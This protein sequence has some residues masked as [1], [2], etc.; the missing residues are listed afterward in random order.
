M[1]P[2]AI[3]AITGGDHVAPVN[4]SQ[5]ESISRIAQFM[6]HAF[7]FLTRDKDPT[8]SKAI[9]GGEELA[10]VESA[11][12]SSRCGRIVTRSVALPGTRTGGL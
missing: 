5:N 10:V 6:I 11:S 2:A 8:F 1:E 12:W 7:T 9:P 4:A 3:C